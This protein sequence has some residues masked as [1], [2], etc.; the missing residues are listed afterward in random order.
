MTVTCNRLARCQSYKLTGR[1]FCSLILVRGLKD[2]GKSLRPDD[3]VSRCASEQPR[4][5]LC[6]GWPKASVNRLLALGN[7][8]GDEDAA[9]VRSVSPYGHQFLHG[10]RRKTAQAVLAPVFKNQIDSR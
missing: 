7:T 3:L 8:H 10:I 4:S 1:W 5:D 6:W 2:S 9:T